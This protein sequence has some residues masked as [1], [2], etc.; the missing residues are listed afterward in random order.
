MFKLVNV[1][2]SDIFAKCHTTNLH[3]A[4][5]HTLTKHIYEDPV[6]VYC[7]CVYVC[8]VCVYMC[9]CVS[10]CEHYCYITMDI[11][12]LWLLRDLNYWIPQHFAYT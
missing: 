6:C 10:V 4:T 7:V 9:V 11:W 2:I 8:G 1:T 12:G 5:N 3:P